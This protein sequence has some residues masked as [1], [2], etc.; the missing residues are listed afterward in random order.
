MLLMMMLTTA[1]AWAE[2]ATVSYI[3]ADGETQK[4][5]TATVLT[6]SETSLDAGWYVVNSN[7]S[8]EGKIDCNGDVNII[9]ADGYTMTVN[10][11]NT[12]G[13]NGTSGSTLTIYGQTNG[14]GTLEVSTSTGSIGA[15][16]IDGNV[17][18]NGGTVNATN[19]SSVGIMSANGSITINDGTVNA[20]G[21][22]Y[23]ISAS[24]GNV[25]ING[26]Q[27]TA[28]NGRDGFAINSVGGV[29]TIT[30]GLRKASD[31]IHANAFSGQVKI[32][33]GQ[34]LTDGTNFY[35]GTLNFSQISD[36]SGKTLRQANFTDNGDNTYA[37]GS[38]YGWGMFCD[39]LL[40]NDTYNRF[41]GKTVKLDADI[42]VSRM[43]GSSKHDFCGTFDGQK[44]TLTVNI[45][46]DSYHDYTAPFSYVSETTPTGSSEVSH[47]VIRNLNVYGT[48]TATKN[49]AGGI[50]GSFWGKLTIENCSSN[51][52]ITTGHKYAAGFISHVEG[53]VDITNCNSSAVIFS[54]VNGDGTHGGFTGDSKSGVTINIT[55]CLFGGSLLSKEGV[56]TTHCSGFVG[57]NSGT[58]TI[59]N[60]LFYPGQISVSGDGSATFARG[61]APTLANC[62]YT[63]TLGEAQ[64]KQRRTIKAGENV[65]IGSKALTGDATEYNVSGITA[66]S[67][68]GLHC[69]SGDE[70]SLY[71]GIG[72]QVS[73][74]LANSNGDAPLGYCYPYS[75][76][77][78]TLNLTPNPS[79]SG[80]G[81]YTLQM[82]DDDV[83]VSVGDLRSDGQSHS[84]SYIKADGTIATHDAIALDET[85]TTLDAG[86]YFV[87]KNITYGQTVTLGADAKIILADGKTMLIGEVYDRISGRC[88]AG[89]K[90]LTIYGQIGQ[91]GKLLA[92]NNSGIFHAV[93]VG[94]Y[95]QHGGEVTINNSRP[96][97]I[98]ANLTL[99]RGTLKASGRIDG[100]VTFS[101]GN[102]TTKTISNKVTLSWTSPD[103]RISAS[104]YKSSVTIAEGKAFY[105]G[106]EVLTAGEVTDKSKVNSRKLVPALNITL[107]KGVIATG[108]GV[109]TLADGAYAVAGATVTLGAPGYTLSNVSS[110][111]VTI[112]ETEGVYSFTMPAS[113]VTI[114]AT[115]TTIPWSGT[116]DVDSPYVIEYPSQLDLLAT[117]V[118]GGN[119]YK[120]TYFVLA[121]DITYSH[122]TAWDDATSEENNYTAIGG[123]NKSF[124]G[125]FDGQGHSV[126][127]IRISKSGYN[128]SDGNQGIFGLTGDGAV[129]RGIT[130]ADARIT[131]CD[132]TG[133]IVGYMYS[134]GTVIDCHVAANV[135][136][137]AYSDFTNGFGGIVGLNY[138]GTVS[139]CTSAATP[140]KGY[141][142]TCLGGIVGGNGGTLSHNLAIGAVVCTGE[143]NTHGA[144]CGYKNSGTFTNNYYYGCKVAS[145][146]VTATGVGCGIDDGN[147]G[148]GTT[149][150]AD[151]TENNGAVPGIILYDKSQKTDLNSD[152]LTKVGNADVACVELAGRTLYKDGYWNTLCLPFDVTVGSD[153]LKGATAMTLNAST[154]SFDKEGGVLTLNFNNVS[155][156]NTIEA[157]TP[158][159]VKWD[160]ADDVTDPVFTGVTVKEGLNNVE[161][162]GGWFKGTY[163]PLSWNAENQ[164]ILFLGAGNELHWPLA[165]AR[166]NAFRAYFQLMGEACAREFVVN[167]DGETT[168]I[169]STT[170]RT[171]RTDK[172]DAWYT[173]NG[174]RLSAK[175]TTKGIYVKNGKKV[176]IK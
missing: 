162:S 99:T 87:G 120:D 143:D 23:G 48:I 171:D 109:A 156:G 116:G 154:S 112:S 21:K 101:G 66:Y 151:I 144:I 172:A 57:Y 113:D 155:E 58:L 108:A 139:N 174:V 2:T 132:G 14:T 119:E 54:N 45:S 146:D 36:I 28:S 44:H 107:P 126:S 69:D 164:S 117:N 97:Y 160:K 149:T 128:D 137:R 26:G 142:S 133:G 47:P 111:E 79:P 159:I 18:I 121:N 4:S 130:L 29:G 176:V 115:L 9:L 64:G 8:H 30:L 92:Y 148:N 20:N 157:G 83:T 118:N 43:A 100:S 5:V 94:K 175:P 161:F 122:T 19:T 61:N 17:V 70:E 59:T 52:D 38:S 51:V 34:R 169:I 35:T 56:T 105:N 84:I 125:T 40:D 73:L 6:G 16:Y 131:G 42:E 96:Y 49:Y 72:D 75:A 22:V 127:G 123:Y 12:N 65:I 129:I 67:G 74:T 39:A 165:G 33:S 147:A 145:D 138:N 152:I 82:P 32:K 86:W 13:L 55:G 11:G 93:E 95:I 103:D 78:G 81:S 68:G 37:I 1:T 3:D 158:F 140:I 10:G 60:S 173:V 150:T 91:S 76:S 71:Y 80:E 90:T 168:G 31:F 163:A 110:S 25:T 102:L 85:M 134:G 124:C 167:F 104:S 15:I 170:D 53:D 135:T 41:S 114:T 46:S 77:D 141:K 98:D 24:H 50:V 63:E 166:L 62:Y 106:S 89:N 7:I 88:I 27:V 136:I 153:V